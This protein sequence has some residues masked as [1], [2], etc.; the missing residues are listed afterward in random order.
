M[1][2]IPRTG[3]NHS[4]EAPLPELPPSPPAKY[5]SQEGT[6]KQSSAFNHE[7]SKRA[8]LK[9]IHSVTK[10]VKKSGESAMEN[11]LVS[12]CIIIISSTKHLVTIFQKDKI[13]E[14]RQ[15][16]EQ[17]NKQIANLN[18]QLLDSLYV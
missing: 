2:Y 3:L 13:S 7:A 15:A 17:K 14:F 6:A 5:P 10:E 4:F 12:V 9:E 11:I 1:N 8:P 16:I 18:Q